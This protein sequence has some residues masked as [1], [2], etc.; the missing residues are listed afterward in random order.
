MKKNPTVQKAIKV[1]TLAGA[2]I[3]VVRSVTQLMGAK[4]PKEAVMPIVSLIV[5]V[6]A[7]NYALQTT[8]SAVKVIG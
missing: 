8:P 5:G 7:F 3:L 1:V 2:A 4:A 6:A